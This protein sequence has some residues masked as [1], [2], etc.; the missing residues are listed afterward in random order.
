MIVT[1]FLCLISVLAVWL[2]S[3]PQDGT[4]GI[5]QLIIFCVFFGVSSGSNISLAPVCVGQLCETE[6][7]GRWYASLYTVVSF[8]CLTGIPIAG[9]LLAADGGSYTSLIGFVGACYGGGLICFIW[10]RI[11]K[12]GWSMKKIY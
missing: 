8:G 12:V 1:V 4:R 6:V 11:L 5:A 10:A 3:S 7:F 9:Q 2:T